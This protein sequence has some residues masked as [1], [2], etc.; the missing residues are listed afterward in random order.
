MPT[1]TEILSFAAEIRRAAL[2]GTPRNPSGVPSALAN[3]LVAQ[4]QHETG[5][6][7]SNIF[8]TGLNAFGYSYYP[9]SEWQLPEP[10]IVADNGSATAKY[11]SVARSTKEI[12]DWIFRRVREGKFPANLSTITTPEQYA[13]LLKS[14]G[15]F[16]DSASNYAAGMKRFFK[17]VTIGGAGFLILGVALYFILKS[18]K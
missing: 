9:G 3:L 6:F 8:K 17:V 14:T 7:S 16:T 4:A 11:S 10:G 13:E 15:Y 5:N 12:V 1:E 2:E 18:K